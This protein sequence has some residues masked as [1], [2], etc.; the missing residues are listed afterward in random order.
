PQGPA[1]TTGATGPQGPA[2]TTGATGPQGPAGTTG[3]TGPQGPAGSTGATGPQGPAGSTGAT[4]PAGATGATG[5]QGAQ[6]IQ[7]P[8]GNTG[9]TGP[10]G[11]VGCTSANYVIKSNGSA[12]TCSQIYDDGT[13]V[14]IGTTA[15]T[16]KLHVVADAG[17]TNQS[18][19]YA[20]NIN[21]DAVVSYGIRGEVGSTVIGSAGVVGLSTNSGQ[22]EIGVLGDYSL[23]GAPV[24]GLGWAAALSDMPTSRDFGL[25]GT[26][27]FSS[28]TGM[29]ARNSSSGSN[30]I[31]G[32]GNQ[33][34]TGS[35]SASVPTTKGNQLLYC[36]ESPE[37]WFED[38]G[39]GKLVNGEATIYLDPLFIETI[40][41]D[42]EHP[43]HVFLQ[44]YGD[45]NELYVTRYDD[46]FVVKEKNNGTS[47]I[48]FSYKISAKRKHYQD[49]RFGCDWMQPF[50]DN[51]S[52]GEYI[53]P[54][55]V[56]PIKTKQWVEE[57]AAKKE[58]QFQQIKTGNK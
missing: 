16:N 20:R 12:A 2:G 29:Y 40:V 38:Q 53:K 15:P 35:K 48:E 31:Y 46:R 25:F 45:C 43:Y 56:D 36:T 32:M 30:A 10:A 55:E 13:F 26:V 8:T 44:E 3:A 28:G 14:G 57:E 58:A 9:A 5:P 24:F 21:V 4:G 1:G 17:G 27:N 51:T 19:I 52:K 7:G 6:G 47:T 42:P 33:V 18:V 54:Y 23:W 50:E 37:V 41:I 34:V 22:N 11:P 39:F 49:H